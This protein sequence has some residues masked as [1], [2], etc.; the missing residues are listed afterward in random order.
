M[1]AVPTINKYI[2]SRSDIAA[3]LSTTGRPVT[4]WSDAP[5]YP[6]NEQPESVAPYVVYQWTTKPSY[7]YQLQ[8]D[9]IT[10][11]I[12]D[13]DINRMM[14]LQSRLRYYLGQEDVSASAIHQWGLASS[15]LGGVLIK[16][17]NYGGSSRPFTQTQ[18]SGVNGI[19]VTF[20]IQYIDCETNEPLV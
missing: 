17:A 19:G 7:P 15:S 2:W 18:E 9:D 8:F 10:Y 4:G 5:V 3:L 20:R 1:I 14:K 12:W 16:S 11:Y 13:Y 6:I